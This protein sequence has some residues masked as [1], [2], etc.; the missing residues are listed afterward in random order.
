MS[1]EYQQLVQQ[2]WGFLSEEDQAIVGRTRVLLAGCGLGSNIAL[3][4]VRTGFRHFIVADGD[5]VEGSNLNRQAFRREH[6]GQNK[7]LA[8]AAL[9]REV[10]PEA[11]VEAIP[12]FLRVEDAASLVE[13]CD[14][15]VNMVDPGL[16]L[17][18]LL[19]AAKEQGRISLFPLN[20]GFG[21]LVL[22]FGPES[23]PLRTLAGPDAGADLFLRIVE[24]LMPSLP[25]YLWDFAWVAE[26]VRRE[27]I[28]PPQLGVAA[29]LTASL[30][31]GAMIKVAL[32]SSLPLVPN[33]LALDCRDPACLSW[34]TGQERAQ[35]NG[36]V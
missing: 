35:T 34:P 3:L 6:V 32:G 20:I 21:G 18:A 23:P 7:A 10:Y 28:A 12:A 11:Q 8:T 24:G 26:R 14:V 9:V 36:G 25:S 1:A 13:R 5:S 22:A 31:V 19:E 17:L 4:A 2:N 30:V 15:V 27:R 16:V 29:S 33:V